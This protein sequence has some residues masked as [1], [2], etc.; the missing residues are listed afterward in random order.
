MVFG[1]FLWNI[2]E[3]CTDTALPGWWVKI[4]KKKKNR[5]SGLLS[6]IQFPSKCWSWACW[7]RSEL[8]LW[9]LWPFS[10][11]WDFLLKSRERK[12]I[13][14]ILPGCLVTVFSSWEKKKKK[15]GLLSA[16][17]AA[18]EVTVNSR[19]ATGQG[20]STLT[21]Q[22]ALWLKRNTLPLP[23]VSPRWGSDPSVAWWHQACLLLAR[24]GSQTERIRGWRRTFSVC[25]HKTFLVRVEN[26]SAYR[27]FMETIS[28]KAKNV[29]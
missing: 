13:L 4:N 1:C 5:S 9:S 14:E 29:T 23:P 18:C 3:I 10:S 2:L 20:A 28:P 25:F 7:E 21:C 24:H 17:P 27:N 6:K 19:A 8:V 16:P 22:P 11:F 26:K 15:K 12:D